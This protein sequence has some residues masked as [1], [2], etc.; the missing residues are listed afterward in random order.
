MNDMELYPIGLSVEEARECILN[1]CAA[2]DSECIALEEADGR[3]LAEDLF[4]PESIPPFPRSPYDGYALRAEDTRGAAKEHGVTL[5]V[6]EEVPAGCAPTKQVERGQAVKILTGAPI[7]QSA[8]LVVKFEDTQFTAET[9]TI[10]APGKSGEN[11][12]PVGED[13]QEGDPVAERGTVLDGAMLGVLAGL[14][15]TKLQVFRMPRVALIST[16][17]ELMEADAALLP[18]K[19]R[20]SSVYTLASYVRRCGAVSMRRGIVP[21]QAPPIAAAIA[22]AAEQSDLVLTTGGVSVGDYDMLRKALE[23]LGADILFW[24]IRMKPGAAFVAA[25]YQ[26][27][28]ILCLSG[29]PSAAV[30][31]FFLLGIPAL[32]RMAGRRDVELEKIQVRLAR[33]FGKKSPNRRFLPGKLEI[34]GGNAYLLQAERQGNGM[35]HPLYGCNLLGEVPAGSPPMEQGSPIEAYCLFL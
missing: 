12:V 18:G 20:N 26:G 10:F 17:D 27:K 34:R 14:G 11:I 5:R 15:Y 2:L 35:L 4:A 13:I 25:V 28:L 24:K 30:V 22:Q 21:D 33:P 29:N 19:I 32:R 16:G 31:A 3:V 1:C 8:D 23:L 6:I 7:P 9:V